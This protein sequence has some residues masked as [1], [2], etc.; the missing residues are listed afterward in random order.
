[1]SVLAW[2][3]A[4]GCQVETNAGRATV[5]LLSGALAGGGLVA[6]SVGAMLGAGT[7]QS[8]LAALLVGTSSAVLVFLYSFTAFALGLTL[9][10]PIWW[11]LHALGVRCWSA[12][13][14]L[15][16][17]LSAGAMWLLSGSVVWAAALA[18]VGALVGALIWKVAYRHVGVCAVAR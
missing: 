3:K 13:A 10:V 7:Q 16:A 12:S 9:T 8:L 2:I 17:L 14:P 11:G 5:A 15:G 18:A 6:I 1:M 4:H